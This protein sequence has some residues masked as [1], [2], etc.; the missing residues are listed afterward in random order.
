MNIMDVLFIMV[1]LNAYIVV[2]ERFEHKL[3][4]F[5]V[6]SNFLNNIS[7]CA[8]FFIKLR[9]YKIS[10]LKFEPQ[11]LKFKNLKV[12]QFKH[13]SLSHKLKM[14]V[15]AIFITI[16]CLKCQNLKTKCRS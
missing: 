9:I 8:E 6:L 4:Y 16:I 14:N 10:I 2:L 11:T 1:I 5:F 12:K 13:T 7:S 3:N 15:I